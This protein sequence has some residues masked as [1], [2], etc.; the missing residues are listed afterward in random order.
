MELSHCTEERHYIE[1][2]YCLKDIEGYLVLFHCILINKKKKKKKKNDITSHFLLM[3][4]DKIYFPAD[5]DAF[6]SKR[7]NCRK[8][9]Q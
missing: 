7:S 1:F 5:V 8:M 2:I 4:C 9:P 3:T 6:I